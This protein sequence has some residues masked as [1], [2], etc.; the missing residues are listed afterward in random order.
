MS[1]MMLKVI[2]LV[3]RLDSLLV[4]IHRFDVGYTE[5]FAPVTRFG[6]IELLFDLAVQYGWE[7]CQID[8]KTT[9]LYGDLDE[10]IYMELPKGMDNLKIHVL[11]HKKVLYGLKQARCQ[12]YR[13]LKNTISKFGLKQA[14]KKPTLLLLKSCKGQKVCIDHTDLCR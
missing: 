5:T 13:K 12:L 14:R 8:V 10:E 4:V 2:S 1:N 7:V 3:T 9:Y 6:I 11:L